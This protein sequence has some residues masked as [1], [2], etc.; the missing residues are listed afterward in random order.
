MGHVCKQWSLR[1]RTSQPPPSASHRSSSS[2]NQPHP[3]SAHLSAP[4]RTA[5]PSRKSPL[6][7]TPSRGGPPTVASSAFTWGGGVSKARGGEG[8]HGIAAPSN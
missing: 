5:S 3:P 1:S 7:Y 4:C 2:P 6:M 8:I